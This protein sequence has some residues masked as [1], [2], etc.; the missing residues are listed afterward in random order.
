MPWDPGEPWPG[1]PGGAESPSWSQYLRLYVYAAIQAGTTFKWGPAPSDRLD[2]GNVY[3][4]G[5]GAPGPP[6][7]T[8]RLWVDLSCDVLNLETHLGGTRPDGAI[9]TAEAG[10]ANVVLID[11]ERIYDP[12]NPESPFQYGGRSRL[13]PGTPILIWAEHIVNT[14]GS[15]LT[16]SSDVLSTEAGDQL[17]TEDSAVALTTYRIH[18]GTVDTWTAP[19][20]AHPENRQVSIVSSDAVKDLVS[21]NFGEQ[22]PVGA[23]DTVPARIT[24]VLTHYGWTGPTRLDPSSITLQATTLASSAWELIGRA[25]EDEIGFVYVDA[26]GVLQFHNRDTW[27]SSP[28]PALS[29]GCPEGYDAMIAADVQ[30]ANLDI[31]NAVYATIKG[32]TQQVAR[33]DASIQLYGTQSYKRTDLGLQ[34]DALAAS[35]ATYLVTLQG[36]P[37]ARVDSVTA[38]PAFTEEIWPDLL[39]LVLV[40]DRVRILWSPPDGT[41]A[42]DTSG[43]AI[44]IDHRISRTSWETDINLVLADLFGR[45]L[46]W[47]SHPDDRLTFGYVFR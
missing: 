43:R 20:S 30:S 22:P 14:G 26:W 12:L 31:R 42:V 23:G 13:M 32:G 8:G 16:E 40:D 7:P 37:R 10:T 4:P 15:L 1:T 39:G 24:R 34:S 45:V 25:S 6:A 19:W 38:Y 46:H 3:G 35:W 28:A 9:A 33:S 47:G 44:G 21:L 18:N 11:P 41:P 27:A 36:F 29:L 17:V 2:A 5:T